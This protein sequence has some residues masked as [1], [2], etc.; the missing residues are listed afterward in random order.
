MYLLPE[1]SLLDGQLLSIHVF[2]FGL[3]TWTQTGTL[4][5][6]K[7]FQTSM[8]DDGWK[9]SGVAN[10]AIHKHYTL[11]D[12]KTICYGGDSREEAE[13]LPDYPLRAGNMAFS[14]GMTNRDFSLLE[15]IIKLNETTDLGL[16]YVCVD[17]ANGYTQSFIEYIKKV[18]ECVGTNMAIIAGNVVTREMA[19][20]LL[21]AGADII[22]VGIGPGSAC[23][24]RKVAGVG[25]PQL[26]AV[27]EC[28]DAAHGLDGHIMAD[29]GC[30]SPGDVAKAFA[31][32]ADFCD[33]WGYVCRDTMNQAVMLSTISTPENVP[34]RRS[35]ECLARLLWRSTA[36]V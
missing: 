19:E 9:E 29:G 27:A 16:R 25:Y 15:E 22:K 11:D 1:T 26:S 2:Q 34:T 31:A 7:A 18:R 12:W 36:V 28:A 33:D 8:F 17:V 32:G 35:M 13:S 24:T 5:I 23:T 30:N 20:A 10:V 21:L 3:Q 14:C 6:A 4:E